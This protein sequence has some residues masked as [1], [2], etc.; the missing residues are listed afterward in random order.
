MKKVISLRN[1]IVSFVTKICMVIITENKTFEELPYS[2]L[3]QS[4]PHTKFLVLL[5]LMKHFLKDFICFFKKNSNQQRN[6][7]EF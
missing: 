2:G 5:L 3:H 4:T 7:G 6:I 1:L